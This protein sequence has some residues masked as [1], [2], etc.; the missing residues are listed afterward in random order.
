MSTFSHSL[1]SLR[2]RESLRTCY[3]FPK[4][5]NAP[6]RYFRATAAT[7]IPDLESE[8]PPPPPAPP[9]PPSPL[10]RT[11]EPASTPPNAK[12]EAPPEKVVGSRRRRQAIKSSGTVPFEQL[13]YQ[14]FQEARKVMQQDREAADAGCSKIVFTFP[15]FK[16]PLDQWVIDI[17]QNLQP[18]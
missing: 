1:R 8:P 14:C 11:E 6:H 2:T 4:C 15:I 12:V 13:P 18:L 3:Q 10:A 9:A 7:E 16:R 5:R 17:S